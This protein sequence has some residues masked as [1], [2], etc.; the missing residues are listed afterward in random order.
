MS[1]DVSGQLLP[2]IH[3]SLLFLAVSVPLSLFSI[4][5]TLKAV[6]LRPHHI[7]FTN[8]F[9]QFRPEY[10]S[11]LWYFVLPRMT[12]HIH[13]RSKNAPKFATPV[14]RCSLL[15][16][17]ALFLPPLSIQTACALYGNVYTLYCNLWREKKKLTSNPAARVD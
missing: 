10:S 13:F 11:C 3:F 16:C 12:R 1:L 4:E 6:Y 2:Q 9:R 5:F 14:S 17:T 8:Q 7:L 15:L